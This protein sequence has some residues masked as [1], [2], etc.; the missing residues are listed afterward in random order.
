MKPDT[1]FVDYML[2]VTAFFMLGALL[3][4]ITGCS[5]APD[6]QDGEVLL[7]PPDPRA[8]VTMNSRGEHYIEP[9]T[10]EEDALY[11]LAD[12][13]SDIFP[14]DKPV[15]LFLVE[16]MV[17]QK[18]AGVAP[19][20]VIS[21]GQTA[22]GL[23]APLSSDVENKWNSAIYHGLYSGQ[24]YPCYSGVAPAGGEKCWFPKYKSLLLSFDPQF[25]FCTQAGMTV[26]VNVAGGLMQE[27]QVAMTWLDWPA[28]G[29]YIRTSF[30][31]DYTTYLIAPFTCVK[32]NNG[33][34]G[35]AVITTPSNTARQAGLPHV[36]GGHDPEGAYQYTNVKFYF[37]P[38]MLYNFYVTTCHKNADDTT[39][40]AG[41]MHYSAAHEMFHVLGFGH[42]TTGV[43]RA[44]LGCGA[45][46]R[47]NSIN[48]V[49]A[50]F[51]IQMSSALAG[52]EGS[53]NNN[54]GTIFQTN[55]LNL[56]P[57]GDP[58]QNQD[59]VNGL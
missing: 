35:Q 46:F 57:N 52:Y 50:L 18:L 25:G 19:V 9:V 11:T 23:E 59:V 45:D 47:A 10:P 28:I 12:S 44:S 49:G 20:E 30:P 48:E 36:V 14:E 32:T 43:M 33:H 8:T 7:N 17:D 1:R 31:S 42:F 40:M 29:V 6:A 5:G 53:H 4:M 13:N 22:M 38:D 3:I 51:S 24:S 21:F 55:L 58:N 2:I 34:I 39:Q 26:P 27:A 15:P 56:G 37:Y 16:P 54:D 41:A